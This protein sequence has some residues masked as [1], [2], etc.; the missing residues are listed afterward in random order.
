MS[1]ALRD[2]DDLDEGSAG[3]HGGSGMDQGS[4]RACWE[5]MAQS[6]G[7][8]GRVA[9]KRA[10]ASVRAW[11]GEPEDGVWLFGRPCWQEGCRVQERVSLNTRAI[12]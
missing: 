3:S 6:R 1:T 11:F 10:L 2:W 4:E 8:G 9:A 5:L 7:L 12:E